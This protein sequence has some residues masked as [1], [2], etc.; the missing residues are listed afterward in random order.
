[1]KKFISIITV[2]ILSFSVSSCREAEEMTALPER[3][4]K[5]SA[6]TKLKKDSTEISKAGDSTSVSNFTVE[7]KDPPRDKI[8]W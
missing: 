3:N 6:L 2:L 5:E 7:E 4:V 8:K 1:M